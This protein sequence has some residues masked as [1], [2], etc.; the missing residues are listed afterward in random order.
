MLSL[1]QRTPSD[2]HP[3]IKEHYYYS[4]TQINPHRIVPYGPNVDI[5]P[6]DDKRKAEG[7]DGARKAAK[8]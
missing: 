4:H 6:L 2:T 1:P 3:D 7:A 8:V 5:E